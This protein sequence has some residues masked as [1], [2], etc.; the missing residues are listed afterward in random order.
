MKRLPP[1]S[2]RTDTRF[3]YTTLFRSHAEDGRLADAPRP[4][5]RCRHRD[6]ALGR[7][8][9]REEMSYEHNIKGLVG[10]KIGMTQTWDE[11]NKIVPVTVV[12]AGDRKS[13][14]LNSSH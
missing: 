6:Q 11:N 7:R 3:P 13:T 4:S 8:G 10:T 9:R 12:A 1:R 14:R 2:T 5:C